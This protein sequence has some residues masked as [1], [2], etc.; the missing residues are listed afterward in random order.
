MTQ[1]TAFAL[2]DTLPQIDHP[3]PDRLVNGNPTRMTWN[4]YESDGVSSGLWDCEPGAWRIAFAD[5]KDE[6]FHVIAGR[7]RITDDEGTAREFGPGDAGV[8]PARFI[9]LFEVLEHVRKHY[10]II[11]RAAMHHK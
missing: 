4:H 2:C 1:L 11:D 5:G 9:G 3:R 6:F 8:I 10:V 7:F